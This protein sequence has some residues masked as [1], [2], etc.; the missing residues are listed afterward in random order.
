MLDATEEGVPCNQLQ[1]MLTKVNCTK[2]VQIEASRNDRR[3]V[4]AQTKIKTNYSH[5]DK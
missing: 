3:K 5:Q 2:L 4:D 1:T